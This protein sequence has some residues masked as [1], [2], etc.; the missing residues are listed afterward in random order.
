MRLRHAAML[1]I[2]IS[3]LPLVTKSSAAGGQSLVRVHVTDAYGNPVPARK[4][5]L[6]ADGATTPVVQD[7]A[8]GVAYG[9]YVLAVYVQGFDNAVQSVVV[10]QPE[11]IVTVAM[12][13]GMMEVPVPRCSI[14]GHVSPETV[15]VRM[16]LM[17]VFG[18]Y[19]ADVPVTRGAFEFRGL[20]CGEYMLVVMGARECLGTKIARATPALPRLDVS[21]DS[22]KGDGCT[23]L[24]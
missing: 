3:A 20:E 14:I 22:V 17:Q 1:V 21:I 2:V 23:S 4:I 7:E 13:L 8:F 11:Q 10:D 18:A 24:K 15:A 16:R 5:T 9:R 6:T 19:T 12:K